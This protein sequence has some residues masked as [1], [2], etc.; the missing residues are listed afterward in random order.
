MRGGIA[1]PAACCWGMCRAVE[2][3]IE[4]ILEEHR[5]AALK[6]LIIDDPTFAVG[7]GFVNL[8]SV[9]L[10]WR[11]P[12]RSGFTHVDHSN[13]RYSVVGNLKMLVFPMAEDTAVDI[14]ELACSLS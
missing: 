1:L 12:N 6:L 7:P 11:E 3:A 9:T 10:S 14:R 8:E 2:G 5:T 4:A 13:C